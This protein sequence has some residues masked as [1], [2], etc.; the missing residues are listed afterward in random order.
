MSIKYVEHNGHNGGDDRK[1][2]SSQST[3][4]V[5]LN[6]IPFNIAS[7]YIVI[8]SFYR[9][10]SVFTDYALNIFTMNRDEAQRRHIA[11]FNKTNSTDQ[12]KAIILCR[13]TCPHWN[14]QILDEALATGSVPQYPKKLE[15]MNDFRKIV[16]CTTGL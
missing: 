4:R 11:Q 1:V 10:L 3:V 5:Y 13:L 15:Q 7:L 12:K 14:I 6:E 2:G 16:N 8:S 9:D